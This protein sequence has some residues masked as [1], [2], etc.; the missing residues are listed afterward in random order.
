MVRIL[1]FIKLKLGNGEDSRFW[2]DKW[3]EGDVLR[4]CSRPCLCPWI[5]TK[6]FQWLKLKAPSLEI[7]KTI[8]L[9]PRVDGTYGRWRMMA[10]FRL[11]RFARHFRRQPVSE[12]SLSTRVM[13]KRFP[14]GG[15]VPLLKTHVNEFTHDE[16]SSLP[17][18]ASDATKLFVLLQ[19]LQYNEMPTHG[20]VDNMR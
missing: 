2:L 18:L 14:H 9:V 16:S 5:L 19:V 13:E 3:Y 17:E 11:L 12:E 20:D 4:G 8:T 6:L 7:M 10:H 15:I 1:D